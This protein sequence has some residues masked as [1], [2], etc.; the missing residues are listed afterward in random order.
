MGIPRL[1]LDVWDGSLI[2]VQPILGF[3]GLQPGFAGGGLCSPIVCW[4]GYWRA[5][6]EGPDHEN[7]FLASPAERPTWVFALADQFVWPQGRV[8]WRSVRTSTG[9][10]NHS[11][12]EEPL[13]R[14][15]KS[16]KD[17]LRGQPGTCADSDLPALLRR[18]KFKRAEVK[19]TGSRIYDD[20]LC[21][22]A[23]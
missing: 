13:M 3:R 14:K 19:D 9:R 5:L 21:P 17:S 15:M 11:F 16:R 2:R 20:S 10:G 12:W 22:V 6:V 23:Q 8:A 4:T 18:V 1:D 7:T